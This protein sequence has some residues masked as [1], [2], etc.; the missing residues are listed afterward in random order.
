[1][2]S[3]GSAQFSLASDVTLH[4]L[5][6]NARE[7]MLCEMPGGSLGKVKAGTGARDLLDEVPCLYHRM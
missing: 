6:V 7:K 1:M 5:S 2:D 4:H 3:V